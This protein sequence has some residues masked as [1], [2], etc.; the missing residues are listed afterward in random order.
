V[1]FNTPNVVYFKYSDTI[2][3]NYPIV[4]FD[5]L[6]EASIS[7]RMTKDQRDSVRNASDVDEEITEMVGNATVFL[8]GICNVKTL[9]LSYETLE[10]LNFCYE[11]IPVFNKLTHLTIDSSNPEVGWESL[12]DLLKNCP[13]LETL[14]FH[15]LH[16]KVTDRCGDVCLCQGLEKCTSSLS[17]CPVKFLTI[18]KFGEAYDEGEDLNMEI[19]M[20]KIKHFLK[21][22]TNLEKL[23]IN[24]N[25]SVENDLVEVSSQLQMLPEVASLKCKIQVISDTLSLSPTFLISLSMKYGL[26][27]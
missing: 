18:M 21:K 6:V 4:N 8:M 24:Y 27:L 22:M 5:S 16:H 14:V 15:G 19:E 12:P 9:Y 1:S 26:H 25:T 11:A 20:E 3:Q 17:Q 23:V 13:N 7:I 10:M 2:A